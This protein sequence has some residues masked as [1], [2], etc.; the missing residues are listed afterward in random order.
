MVHLLA[1]Q[2]QLAA[3]LV[4][5]RTAR[6]LY[7]AGK[8]REVLRVLIGRYGRRAASRKATSSDACPLHTVQVQQQPVANMSAC[9]KTLYQYKPE[10]A[11]CSLTRLDS[12][13]THLAVPWAQ[14]VPS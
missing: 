4:Q 14:R 12:A 5:V 11:E 7:A 6:A 8:E 1:A 2:A 3:G 10:G 9:A 13:A